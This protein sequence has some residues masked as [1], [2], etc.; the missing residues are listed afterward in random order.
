MPFP[1]RPIL[2]ALFGLALAQ[3][4][5]AELAACTTSVAGLDVPLFY[6]P[7]DPR[8]EE[9]TTRREALLGD[10]GGIT[11]PGFVTLRYLTPDLTD[12]Q[13]GTF[14]LQYDRS[15]GTY[16]G[17]AAGARNA[18][19][20]CRAPTKGFCERVN[21]SRPAALAITRFAADLTGLGAVA[22]IAEDVSVLTQ[23]N[24]AVTVSGTGAE[25][26]GALARIGTTAVTVAAA[27]APLGAAAVT[28]VAVGGIVYACRD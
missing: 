13:R 22:D 20:I 8:V 5:R 12:D 2:L 28:V 3:V 6:D 18:Y 11:C 17:Y 25:V 26:A 16:T 14:C 21:D 19:A 23:D 24:G 1:C 10:W 9:N 15:A 27:P 4:A 7:S